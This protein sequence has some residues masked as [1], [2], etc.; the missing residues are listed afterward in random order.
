[1]LE[2]GDMGEE[3]AVVEKD[4]EVGLRGLG[5]SLGE[6]SR[7]SLKLERSFVWSILKISMKERRPLRRVE[8]V[9]RRWSWSFL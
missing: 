4:G 3:T 8:R 6:K 5:W 7:R 9:E 2:T 1:M